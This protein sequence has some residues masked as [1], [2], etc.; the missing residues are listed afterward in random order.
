[1]RMALLCMILVLLCCGS[2]EVMGQEIIYS[3]DVLQKQQQ[4]PESVIYGILL[5]QAAAFKD[6]ADELDR[7][8][9]DGSPYRHHMEAKF[10]LTSQELISLDKVAIEYRA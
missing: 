8:G 2:A 1:M 4:V 3:P 10:G 5:H 9:G 7:S 6:K